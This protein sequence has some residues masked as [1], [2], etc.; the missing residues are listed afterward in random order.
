VQYTYNGNNDVVS[1]TDLSTNRTWTYGYDTG[2]GDQSRYHNLASVS[3]PLEPAGM[4]PLVQYAYGYS[5]SDQINHVNEQVPL[6]PNLGGG[7]GDPVDTYLN[8]LN[9]PYQVTAHSRDG[10][11]DQTTL[12]WY[13]GFMDVN[14]RE[15]LSQFRAGRTEPPARRPG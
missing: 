6:P 10:M 7:P 15:K 9:L 12:F 1:A 8:G 5:A 11:H 14:N 13:D 3:T 4:T 2:T